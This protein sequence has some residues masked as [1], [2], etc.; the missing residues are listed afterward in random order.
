[1]GPFAG[2]HENREPM[3]RVLD[4]HRA[5]AAGIDEELAPP[6]VLDAARQAWDEACERAHAGGVRNSQA[7]VLAPTGTIGLLMDC[8][9]TGIE[10]D[11]GLIKI[12][13]LVGGGTMSIVNQ[14]VPRALRGPRLPTTVEGITAYIDQHNTILGAP[15]PVAR[16]H[17]R[18]RLLHGDN[19]IHY[20]GHVKMMGAVQPFLSGGISKTV[21][22]PE[23]A[24]VEEIELLLIESWR[25]GLK[26][27]ALYRDNCKVAQPLS[28][29]D[30][31]EGSAGDGMRVRRTSLGPL[32][33]LVWS[34]MSSSASSLIR[35][36]RSCLVLARVAPLSFGLPIARDSSRSAST[37]WSTRRDLRPGFET[38]VDAGGHHGR[39]C[40]LLEPWLAVRRP[41]VG[42]R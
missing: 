21:N 30:G 40:D 13:R 22:M 31:S 9:T 26:A 23:E 16:A 3:L 7:S 17:Q 33:L 41:V 35:S 1:M 19:P 18:V 24:S 29:G 15:G 36:A 39:L 28:A 11:L 10:P 25:L 14:T 8:D 42:V 12:K 34:R 37:R 2:F 38:G 20:L 5:A 6:L 27:V 32:A 4:Q